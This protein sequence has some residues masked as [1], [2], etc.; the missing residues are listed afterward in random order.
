MVEAG[1]W[2]PP[3][4]AAGAGA[5]ALPK[6]ADARRDTRGRE[7]AG[8]RWAQRRPCSAAASLDTAARRCPSP[9]RSP[10]RCSARPP[11]TTAS[12]RAPPPPATRPRSPAAPPRAPAR[13]KLVCWHAPPFYLRLARQDF[14]M[15]EGYDPQS[16]GHYYRYYSEFTGGPPARVPRGALRRLARVRYAGDP[17][18]FL[19][20]AERWAGG[21]RLQT[22]ALGVAHGLLAGPLLVLAHCS[23][24]YVLAC[25]AHGRPPTRAPRVR[26][27]RLTLRCG[28]DPS[29]AAPS[30]PPTARTSLRCL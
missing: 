8:S 25:S 6:P 15:L 18:R 11:C 2:A 21:W 16:H 4:G 29:R 30:R 9:G 1:C 23:Q 10:G 3:R 13:R 19:K 27:V 20:T 7:G 5:R 24:P 17:S 12:K 14:A 28:P 22:R 26:F